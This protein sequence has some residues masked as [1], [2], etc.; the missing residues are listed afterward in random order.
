MTDATVID[1]PEPDRNAAHIRDRVLDALEA[2][3]VAR[4]M[5]ASDQ[6]EHAAA[7]RLHATASELGEEVFRLLQDTRAVALDAVKAAPGWEV[8]VD[9]QVWH[10]AQEPY[11]AAKLVKGP[12]PVA[13]G[14]VGG[15]RTFD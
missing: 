5:L 13:A 15:R 9:G 2:V 12:K 10:A 8:T 3:Q 4:R 6:P 1:F 11:S 7:V 14:Q